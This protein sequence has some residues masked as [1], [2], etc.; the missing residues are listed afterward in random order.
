MLGAER[1]KTLKLV[2]IDLQG[3]ISSNFNCNYLDQLSLK[4]S[5]VGYLILSNYFLGA[6][7][8]L[9]RFPP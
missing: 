2:I 4:V 1:K 8:N 7:D 3:E 5:Q 9:L 6:H